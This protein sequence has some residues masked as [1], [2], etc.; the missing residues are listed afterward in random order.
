MCTQCQEGA[1]E[2]FRSACAPG[3]GSTCGVWTKILSSV[4][5]PCNRL[6]KPSRFCGLGWTGTNCLLAFQPLA[7]SCPSALLD[8]RNSDIVAACQ[9]AALSAG[10]APECATGSDVLDMQ[11]SCRTRGAVACTEDCQAR[12][13]PLFVTCPTALG[14][15]ENADIVTACGFGWAQASA[16]GVLAPP[17]QRARAPEFRCAGGC[18]GRGG[19]G[20]C[21]SLHTWAAAAAVARNGWRQAVRA[22]AT[23]TT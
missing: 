11:A 16:L 8:T 4:L 21:S 3:G 1:V 19:A 6:L 12:L 13:Q 15:A 9:L 2:A 5:L 17:A 10:G 18:C 20:D 7:L 22:S 14:A 23:R